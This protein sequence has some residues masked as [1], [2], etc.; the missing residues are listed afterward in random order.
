MR[1]KDS[2]DDVDAVETDAEIENEEGGEDRPRRR[3][4]R[5]ERVKPE[6]D[7]DLG[8]FSK[9]SAVARSK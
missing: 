3:R 7:S 8:G 5:R 9:A 2:I 4:R 1:K 6:S